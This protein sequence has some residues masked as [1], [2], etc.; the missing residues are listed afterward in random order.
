MPYTR[1]TSDLASTHIA[2]SSD[3]RLSHIR[4]GEEYEAEIHDV[5]IDAYISAIE[6]RILAGIVRQQFPGGVRR[7]LDFACGTGRIARLIEPIATESF[8]VDVSAP[9]LELARARCARTRFACR[10]SRAPGS[11]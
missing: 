5:P 3:Y 4:K 7:Y 6:E 11:L 10:A 8:G 1:N 2:P 9:M